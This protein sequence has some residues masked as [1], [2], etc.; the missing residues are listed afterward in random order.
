[1]WQELSILLHQ[2]IWKGNGKHY[3]TSTF[4]PLWPDAGVKVWLADKSKRLTNYLSCNQPPFFEADTSLTTNISCFT[5][6]LSRS[7]PSNWTTTLS[8]ATASN[9]GSSAWNPSSHILEGYHCWVCLCFLVHHFR[10]VWLPF[11]KGTHNKF[12]ILGESTP[13]LWQAWYSYG[14]SIARLM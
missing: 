9:L 13:F 6:S 2:G 12:W 14:I 7:T 1:M 3:E 4:Q 11:L 10:Q 5:S 8:M